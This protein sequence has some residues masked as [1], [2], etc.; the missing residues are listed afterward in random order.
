MPFAHDEIGVSKLKVG[1]CLRRLDV[2]CKPQDRIGNSLGDIA[3]GPKDFFFR[4]GDSG[5]LRE[6]EKDR[7]K[8]PGL[9]GMTTRVGLTGCGISVD[10]KL[11][12][13]HKIEPTYESEVMKIRPEGIAKIGRPAQE[14]SNAHGAGKRSFEGI[15]HRPT[16]FKNTNTH[17]VYDSAGSKRSFP[18][19][20]LKPTAVLPR[21]EDSAPE[22]EPGVRKFEA[23]LSQD[24]RSLTSFDGNYYDPAP[25][26]MVHHNEPVGAPN[27]LG[28]AAGK[29]AWD[30]RER[31][32]GEAE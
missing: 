25:H 29:S 30:K 4:G 26:K 6:V 21:W 14:P 24:T 28:P 22:F 3:P 32:S 9:E 13:R 19:I 16:G 15:T 20:S 23:S 17:E 2:P 5:L 11:E 31:L 18:H 7:R 10:D 8:A 27:A 1:R 12:R